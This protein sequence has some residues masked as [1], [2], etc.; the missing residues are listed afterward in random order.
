M[1]LKSVCMYTNTGLIS[2]SVDT[3]VQHAKATLQKKFKYCKNFTAFKN[4][5]DYIPRFQ[6]MCMQG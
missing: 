3:A 2:Y 4:T 5:Q 6:Y 1:I